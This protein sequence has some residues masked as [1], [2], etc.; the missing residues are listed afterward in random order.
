MRLG[1]II[2]KRFDNTAKE[3]YKQKAHS[4][5]ILH[6]LSGRQKMTAFWF[7]TLE[8]LAEQ[9]RP[10]VNFAFCQMLYSQLSEEAVSFFEYQ[11]QL[12]SVYRGSNIYNILVSEAPFVLQL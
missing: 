3:Y 5:N 4:H 2:W 11:N 7:F 6:G 1:D 12:C 9:Q 8:F 10:M